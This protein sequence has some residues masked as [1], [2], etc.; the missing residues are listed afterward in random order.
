MLIRALQPNQ[1]TIPLDPDS[2]DLPA[3]PT[4]ART[5][6]A[7][8]PDKKGDGACAVW[9]GSHCHSIHFALQLVA[10]DQL[11]IIDSIDGNLTFAI[12]PYLNS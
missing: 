8:Q 7:A 9:R 11:Y 10:T 4:P 12:V 5:S 2:A 1:E 6:Y 3:S